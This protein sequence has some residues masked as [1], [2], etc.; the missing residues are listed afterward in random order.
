MSDAR[1]SPPGDNSFLLSLS[2]HAGAALVLVVLVAGLF[3]ALGQMRADPDGGGLAIGDAGGADT[4]PGTAAP[5][6]P[7]PSVASPGTTSPT[8]AP[9]TTDA[10]PG[11]S[12]DA[13]AGTG[14][15]PSPTPS[16][17]SGSTADGVSP[18]AEEVEAGDISIQVLD[19]VEGNGGAA[20][21]EVAEALAAEGFDVVVTNPAS[22]AYDTTTVFWTQ[23]NEDKAR[24]VAVTMGFGAVDEQPGMLSDSVDV[25]VVVGSDRL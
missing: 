5:G 11:A 20:A 7:A 13:T 25:H 9:T 19:A 15:T 12:P 17:T 16:P 4:V 24:Q 14:S 2:R 23:S 1:H 21:A 3:W 22:V 10:D 8:D 18:P 6:S